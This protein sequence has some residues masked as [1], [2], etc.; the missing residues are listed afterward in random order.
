M[1]TAILPAASAVHRPPFLSRAVARLVEAEARRNQR[2]DLRRLDARLLRDIGITSA[3][4]D[5]A[6][7]R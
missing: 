2:A 6:F 7:R 4:I 3:D 1:I 5:A